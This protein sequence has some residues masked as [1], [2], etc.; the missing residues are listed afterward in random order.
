MAIPFVLE[1]IIFPGRACQEIPIIFKK[2]VF[3]LGLSEVKSHVQC[4]STGWIGGVETVVWTHHSGNSF[5]RLI[6]LAL[7]AARRGSRRSRLFR[8]QE[9]RKGGGA[10]HFPRDLIEMR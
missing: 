4:H 5:P 9:K 6:V 2:T 7:S 10:F 1:N 3:T 8:E